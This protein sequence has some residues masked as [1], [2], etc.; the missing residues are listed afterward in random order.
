[1]IKEIQLH[2]THLMT[3][4]VQIQAD[5]LLE[6]FVH[7][8][9]LPYTDGIYKDG[10]TIFEMTPTQFDE[11]EQDVT[12]YIPVISETNSTSQLRYQASLNI[13]GISKRVPFEDGLDQSIYEM[14]AYIRDHGWELQDKLYLALIPVY[15]D[16]FVDLIIPVEK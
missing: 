15:D 10:P 14:K 2:M 1:M 13:E 16:L 4:Q 12:I 7:T 3:D 5:E 6:L 8:E 9:L 11:E